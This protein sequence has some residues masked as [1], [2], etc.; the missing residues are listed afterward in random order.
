VPVENTMIKCMLIIAKSYHI[1]RDTEI[2][3]VTPFIRMV[4]GVVME[5][6]GI[7]RI[8]FKNYVS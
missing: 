1:I 4:T 2:D 6:C 3:I 7:S 5:M 8:I